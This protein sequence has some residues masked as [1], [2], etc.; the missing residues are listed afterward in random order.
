MAGREMDVEL[1]DGGVKIGS[2]RLAR[3]M[4][5]ADTTGLRGDAASL[6][7]FAIAML[8]RLQI[9]WIASLRP[10]FPISFGLPISR[11]WVQSASTPFRHWLSLT[12]R[13]RTPQERRGLMSN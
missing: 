6:L 11:S 2:R 7:P 12:E 1:N 9:S 5:D 10:T 8:D 13:L 3:L 4:R